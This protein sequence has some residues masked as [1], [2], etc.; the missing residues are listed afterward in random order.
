M[1]SSLGSITVKRS[2][3]LEACVNTSNNCATV[4]LFTDIG[5]IFKFAQSSGITAFKG[6]SVTFSTALTNSF[7]VPPGK[8]KS[9]F[10]NELVEPAKKLAKSFVVSG[11]SFTG[12]TVWAKTGVSTSASRPAARQVGIFMGVVI[13]FGV[14][15]QKHVGRGK[16]LRRKRFYLYN[17]MISATSLVTT[18]GLVEISNAALSRA[19]A[20]AACDWS[21]A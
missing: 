3:F 2:V 9:N 19:Q 7:G 10:G 21:A 11:R 17:A 5:N 6:F 1:E 14:F 4:T 15:I 18:C 16:I 8:F 20:D 13:L 12:T